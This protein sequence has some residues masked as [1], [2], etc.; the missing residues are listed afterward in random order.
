MVDMVNIEQQALACVVSSI[1]VNFVFYPKVFF[2]YK[3]SIGE[4]IDAS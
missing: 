1:I 4:D 3:L 2:V